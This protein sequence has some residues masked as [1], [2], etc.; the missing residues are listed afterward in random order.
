MNLIQAFRGWRLLR[1]LIAQLK[2]AKPMFGYK[3]YIIAAAIGIATA[4]H[5]AGIIDND[6]YLAILG[7]L[8][9]G[10]LAALRAGVSKAGGA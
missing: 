9:A 5:S 3:T 7:F 6:L 4:L 1:R 8:N 2:E 10:G